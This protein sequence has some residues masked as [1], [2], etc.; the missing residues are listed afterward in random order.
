MSASTSVLA[1]LS[2]TG[3]A[4]LFVDASA[5]SKYLL[6]VKREATGTKGPV[7]VNANKNGV[8]KDISK[9]REHAS[10]SARNNLA[11]KEQSGT[12]TNASVTRNS[13]INLNF[14]LPS[15][16]GTPFSANVFVP[17]SRFASQDMSGITKLVT[18]KL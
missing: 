3:S 8:P 15:T 16:L 14:A 2:T 10:V 6:L 9:T 11:L 1:E 7:T 5:K 12:P 4:I 13:A 17:T 18:V